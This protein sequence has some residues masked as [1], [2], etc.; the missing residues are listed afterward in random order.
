MGFSLFA[1][2]IFDV[3]M[4]EGCQERIA[5]LAEN[6]FLLKLVKLERALVVR[7]EVHFGMWVI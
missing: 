3:N 5:T 6:T 4:S 7:D 1:L 2:T